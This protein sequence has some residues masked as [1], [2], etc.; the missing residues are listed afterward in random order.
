MSNARVKRLRPGFQGPGCVGQNRNETFL[1]KDVRGPME[2]QGRKN[3]DRTKALSRL[4]IAKV[5]PAQIKVNVTP[6][7]LQTNY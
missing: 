5:K 1:H 4:G 3:V 7:Q 6:I 2:Q